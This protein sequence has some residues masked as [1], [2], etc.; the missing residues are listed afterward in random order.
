MTRAASNHRQRDLASHT[1]ALT[2]AFFGLGL[3]VAPVQVLG[4]AAASAL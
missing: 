2:G 4:L 1:D 3:R